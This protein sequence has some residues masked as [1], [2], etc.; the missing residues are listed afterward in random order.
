MASPAQ[1]EMD[2][3]FQGEIFVELKAVGELV[4]TIKNVLPSLFGHIRKA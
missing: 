2:A 1:L 3:L 4:N